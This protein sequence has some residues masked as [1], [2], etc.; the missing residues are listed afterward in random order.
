MKEKKLQEIKDSLQCFAPE[1]ANDWVYILLC[2][3][4]RSPKR[5]LKGAS[6]DPFAPSP[7]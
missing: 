3:S 4:A 7:V 2:I 5:D 1:R 6:S